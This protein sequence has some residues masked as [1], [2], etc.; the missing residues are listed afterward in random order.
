MNEEQIL[1][2]LIKLEKQN[3]LFKLVGIVSILGMLV[4]GTIAW[5]TAEYYTYQGRFILKNDAGVT[6]G[7]LHLDKNSPYLALRDENGKSMI[8]LGLNSEGKPDMFLGDRWIS[9]RIQ[10]STRQNDA[11][12]ED[13]Q[14]QFFLRDK[15]GNLRGAFAY[16]PDLNLGKIMLGIS[17]ENKGNGV[18][19]FNP[20][21]I[22]SHRNDNKE[23]F[24]GLY[25]HAGKQRVYLGV[26]SDGKTYF[27]LY[28]SKGKMYWN[29]PSK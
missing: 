16:D 19:G 23:P 8:Y 4:L 2:R 25:D 7:E 6:K 21:I 27:E 18:S 9:D 17:G 10:R 13:H 14:G 1:I 11:G 22:L 15:L 29:A 28:D 12:I 26:G 24:L 20:T 3:R 5:T